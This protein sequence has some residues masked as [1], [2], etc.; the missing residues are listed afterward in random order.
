MYTPL[1]KYLLSA[2]LPNLGLP[3]LI[4]PTEEELFVR[5]VT[6][7]WHRDEGTGALLFTLRVNGLAVI[8]RNELCEILGAQHARES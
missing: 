3:A 1:Q 8:F 6:L 4:N 5:E 2:P 7:G